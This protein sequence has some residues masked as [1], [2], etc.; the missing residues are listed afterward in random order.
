MGGSLSVTISDIY[1]IKTEE[2]VVKPTKPK[3]YRRCVIIFLNALDMKGLLLNLR[4]FF[5][6]AACLLSTVF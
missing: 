3:V 6:I 5:L 2:G 1:M 4:I